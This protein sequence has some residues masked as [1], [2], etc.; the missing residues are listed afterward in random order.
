MKII[1]LGFVITFSRD[2]W[3]GGSEYLLNLINQIKK[4][5][6]DIKPIIL[7][8]YKNSKNDFS[9]FK[10]IKIIQSNIFSN[11]FFSRLKNKLKIIFL[12]KDIILEKFLIKNKIDILSHFFVTGR[13]SKIKSLFWIPDF[14]EI[15]NLKYISFKRKI[16][17]RL[18]LNYAIKNAHNII[19]SS[20]TVKNDFIKI[21]PIAG[22]K[23]IVFQPFFETPK[24]IKNNLILKKYNINRKFFILPNQYWKHKNHFF[25]LKILKDIVLNQKIDV[26]IVSTGNFNDSRFPEYKFEIL[27][28]IKDNNLENNYKILG[29]IPYQDLMDLMHLSIA[30]INPSKSE[31]WSSSVEQG[32]SMGKMILLSNIKVHKEQSPH[33]RFYFNPNKK[34]KLKKIIIK[35]YNEYDAK[36]ELEYK[37]YAQKKIEKLKENFSINYIN[38]I[39]KIFN[40]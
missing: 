13:N 20:N 10:N 18:N 17:R 3:L 25:I 4:N 38:Y 7:T 12:G 14:Q 9:N 26:Q 23:A 33:R 11:T 21:N 2:S 6:N 15:Y 19:L 16:L 40:E 35:L 39:K 27:K 31:G 36:K 8:N 37:F 32:K 24:K 1:N 29:I 22:K 28:F 5:S 30:V 34:D